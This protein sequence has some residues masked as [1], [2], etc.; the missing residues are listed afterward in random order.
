M[1]WISLLFYGCE[2]LFQWPEAAAIVRSENHM[3]FA[4]GVDQKRQGA[5]VGTRTVDQEVLE[6]NFGIALFTLRSLVFPKKA[7]Q[8]QREAASGATNDNSQ[9]GIA[10]ENAAGDHAQGALRYLGVRKNSVGDPRS[11]VFKPFKRGIFC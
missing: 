2:S 10:I 5:R 11:A 4:H 7:M 3:L 6:K 9:I 8:Q 1:C